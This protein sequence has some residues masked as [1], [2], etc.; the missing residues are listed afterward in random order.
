MSISYFLNRLYYKTVLYVYFHVLQIILSLGL[1]IL[2][3]ND[4][5]NNSRKPIVIGLEVAILLFMIFDMVVHSIV[6]GIQA[7]ILSFVEWVVVLGFTSSLALVLLMDKYRRLSEE[8]ELYLLVVRFVLQMV[9]L[10]LSIAKLKENSQRRKS[11]TNI[12]IDMETVRIPKA[13]VNPDLEMVTI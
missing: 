12:E 4:S 11:V 8:V 7:S 1:V 10:L 13:I 5:I 6:N 3:L 2:L 9:R